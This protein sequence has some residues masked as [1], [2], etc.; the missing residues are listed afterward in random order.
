MENT[1]F[2]TITTTSGNP[3]PGTTSGSTVPQ[4]STPG[5]VAVSLI[6]LRF[7]KK[8]RLV[9][10]VSFAGGLPPRDVVSPY[11]KPAYQDVAVALLGVDGDGVFDTLVFTARKHRPHVCTTVPV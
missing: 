8:T 3:P 1:V 6:R 10:E 5:P 2:G 7:G 4:A 9:A 11:Q